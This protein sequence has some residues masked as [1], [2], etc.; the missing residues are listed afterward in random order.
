M[1]YLWLIVL[2]F[3]VGAFGT[4]IGVGGG[5]ILMPVLLLVYP[6]ETPTVLTAISLAVVFF[7]AASGSISYARLKRIDYKSGLAFL[8]AGV[9]GAVLGALAVRFIPRQAFE[10]VFGLLLL[11]AGL[12]ILFRPAGESGPASWL[13][14]RF[15]RTLIEADGTRHEYAFNLPLGVT[16]SFFVGFASSLLGLGGG[17]IHVPAMVHL[18]DFP[19]HVATATSHF[20]L[21]AMALAGTVI[22]LLDGSLSEAWRL[23][24]LAVG[25]VA[26][27]QLG[28]ALSTRVRGRWIMRSLAVALAMVGLRILILALWQ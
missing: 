2:G 16:L 24:L 20:I 7:N 11:A 27:A 23:A 9:P 1:E 3:V 25:A 4:L 14:A 19:V 22:H 10:L 12:Y 13:P 5:F 17:I 28:A 15:K 18:L 21:A 26:G 6:R 8:L